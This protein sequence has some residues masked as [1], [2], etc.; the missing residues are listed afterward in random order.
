MYETIFMATPTMQ[1]YS[2][3]KSFTRADNA[4]RFAEN[5]ARQY[6]VAYAVWQHRP[7]SLRTFAAVIERNEQVVPHL[8]SVQGLT[9][10][11]AR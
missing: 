10:W 4:L 11:F 6:R 3:A 7:Q 1:S 5:A 2:P 8:V 9:G